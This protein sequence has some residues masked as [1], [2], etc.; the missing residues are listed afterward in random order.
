MCNERVRTAWWLPEQVTPGSNDEVREF[1]TLWL[2]PYWMGMSPWKQMLMSSLE[3]GE[4]TEVVRCHSKAD[5]KAGKGKSTLWRN[6]KPVW[7]WGNQKEAAARESHRLKLCMM[8][9]LVSQLT[10]SADVNWSDIYRG[11]ACA[12]REPEHLK[13]NIEIIY[14][15]MLATLIISISVVSV[16][17]KILFLFCF[18]SFSFNQC[19]LCRTVIILILKNNIK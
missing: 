10:F 11:Y 1:K 7:Y 3:Q 6:Y 17:C 8:L 9:R 19:K 16:Y 14:F 2:Y 18:V 12:R 13:Q 5:R 15:F 4:G